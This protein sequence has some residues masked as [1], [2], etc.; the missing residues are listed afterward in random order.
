MPVARNQL[1]VGSLERIYIIYYVVLGYVI[2]RY[3]KTISLSVIDV[4]RE[5]IV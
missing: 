5:I 3:T 1:P 2:I 4:T